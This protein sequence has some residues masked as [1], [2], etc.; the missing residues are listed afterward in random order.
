MLTVTNGNCISLNSGQTATGIASANVTPNVDANSNWWGTIHGPS[1]DEI[2]MYV[3]ASIILSTPPTIPYNCGGTDYINLL[4]N[5]DFSADGD[6]L[7]AWTQVES[8]ASALNATVTEGVL[9]LSN[10]N[11]PEE[12]YLTQSVTGNAFAAGTWF[13]LFMALGD[14]SGMVQE[15]VRVQL[16]VNG[17]L[18]ATC[19]FDLK[20][21][22][23]LARH[24]LRGQ[25]ATNLTTAD[26]L[27]VRIVPT[28]ADYLLVD[29]AILRTTI[30]PSTS[31]CV[32]YHLARG[33]DQDGNALIQQSDV[34][35][36]TGYLGQTV[37]GNP[38]PYTLI[39]DIDGD[40]FVTPSDL[41]S[42][43]NRLG[44]ELINTYSGS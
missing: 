11:P 42:V 15:T 30:E 3:D 16:L 2:S 31:R 35:T 24:T 33:W 18:S 25:L 21:N 26:S 6:G 20:S 13:E 29:N 32:T 38:D 10:D 43:I 4:V 5:G 44:Y 39:A 34:D 22:Q 1:G 19:W 28:T 40:G 27:E 41:L 14:T 17:E 23:P 9:Q 7:T 36:V 8:N 12:A 37:S